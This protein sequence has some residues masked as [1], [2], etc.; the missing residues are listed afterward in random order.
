[1]DDCGPAPTVLIEGSDTEEWHHTACRKRR[2]RH[3]RPH[4][5]P[6]RRRQL[7]SRAEPGGHGINAAAAAAAAALPPPPPPPPSP[8]VRREGGGR[9]LLLPHWAWGTLPP[10]EPPARGQV[11]EPCAPSEDNEASAGAVMLS[12][13]INGYY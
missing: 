11:E 2:P 7:V 13:S 8:V 5:P 9:R 1:M 3:Q 12:I 6:G 10:E 4:A